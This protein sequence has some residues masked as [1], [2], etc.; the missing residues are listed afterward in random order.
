M[1]R[2]VVRLHSA[3]IVGRRLARTA[4]G[5]D[6]VADLLVFVQRTEAGAF[7]C[8]DMNEHVSSA[9]IRSNETEALGA[10]EP[11][12]CADSHLS[13]PLNW[14]QRY[15]AFEIKQMHNPVGAVERGWNRADG[16]DDC[17]AHRL[18]ARCRYKAMNAGPTACV[19]VLPGQP[20]ALQVTHTPETS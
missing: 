6:F 19:G 14:G 11:L 5:N 13:F 20:I 3:E 1:I 4:I 17:T 18:F 9:F 16:A 8:A 7:N 2:S 15:H 12:N 10:V